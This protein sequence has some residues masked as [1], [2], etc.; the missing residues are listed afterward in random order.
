M[1][2]SDGSSGCTFIRFRTET[3]VS[4]RDSI[5]K[6]AIVVDEEDDEVFEDA[7]SDISILT[8]RDEASVHLERSKM[9]VVVHQDLCVDSKKVLEPLFLRKCAPQKVRQGTAP[10]NVYPMSKVEMMVANKVGF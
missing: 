9:R 10:P 4:V 8:K 7:S 5:S 6:Q 3:T 1:C 2:P